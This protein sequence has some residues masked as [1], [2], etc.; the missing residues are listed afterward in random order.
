[1][2]VTDYE[3]NDISTGFIHWHKQNGA[4]ISPKIELADLRNR[5]AGRGVLVKEDIVEDEELFSIPKKLIMTADNSSLRQT[6]DLDFE[7]PWLSLIITMV[8]EHILDNRSLWAPYFDVLPYDFDTLMYWSDLEL[9]SLKGS[10]VVDKIGKKNADATFTEKLL[11]IVRDDKRAFPA[12]LSDEDLLSMFHRMG[13]TIMAYAFDIESSTS[14]SR[15]EEDGWEEDSDAGESLPKGMVPLADMLNADADRNNAKLF[16]EDDKVVMKAI[17][18]ISKGEELFNDYGPLP[19][20]DVLRRYGYVTDNYA[21]YDVVEIP[22]HL[23]IKVTEEKSM[24][25]KDSIAEKIEFLDEVGILEDG[26]D[27]ARATNEDGQF[28]EE[29]LALLNCMTV[30]PAK[31]EK[32]QRKG[33]PPKPEQSDEALELLYHILVYRRSMYPDDDKLSNEGKDESNAL[34]LRSQYRL[35]MAAEVI[36]GEKSVLQEAADVVRERLQHGTKRKA[37]TFESDAMELHHKKRHQ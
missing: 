26:Y 22:L 15:A 30:S 3:F 36:A 12:D 32:L 13:S 11:P 21:K 10:T 25:S 29:L 28:S 31:F 27:I 19:R 23:I 1:M 35:R 4:T 17:K 20:A 33:K 7:D 18:A 14:T 34:S 6:L 9:E 5:S 16:Y 8:Y 37:D 2:P 24:S